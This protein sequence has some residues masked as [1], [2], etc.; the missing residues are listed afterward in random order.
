M[1]ERAIFIGVSIMFF[2]SFYVLGEAITKFMWRKLLILSLSLHRFDFVQSIILFI[3]CNITE[4]LFF[5]TLFW[6]DL[7]CYSCTYLKKKS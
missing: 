3:N 1:H 7:I 5:L 2:A 6:T 4:L